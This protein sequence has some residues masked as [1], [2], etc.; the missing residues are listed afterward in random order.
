MKILR[1]IF[2]WIGIVLSIIF[3]AFLILLIIP[4]KETVPKI[5]PRASTQYWEMDAGFR[6]AYTHLAGKDSLPSS[7]V[8]FLHGGP[9]GYV[10]SSIIEAL[11]KLTHQGFDVYLYDQRGSGLSDRMPKYTDISFEKH[12]LDLHEIITKHIQAEHVI[13]MGQSFGCNI[14]SHYTARH[15]EQV[16]KIIFSSPGTFL[17]H[18]QIDG[19][20]V[21][22]DS[23]YPV[24]DYLKFISPYN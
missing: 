1:K 17:P 15:P 4:E 9:G 3:L 12:L 14:I 21:N 11:D 16:Q 22:I 19:K 10:H 8:V 5:Q 2:K 7:P 13:L 23:L 24:P 6:M 20:Y 18:R